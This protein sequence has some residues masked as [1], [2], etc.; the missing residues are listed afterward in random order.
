[1]SLRSNGRTRKDLAVQQCREISLFQTT[2]S[3][4]FF[5]FWFRMFIFIDLKICLKEKTKHNQRISK[6]VS[7]YMKINI[8]FDSL[9]WRLRGGNL[10]PWN[11]WKDVFFSSIEYLT[12]FIVCWSFGL[13]LESKM[14]KLSRKLPK[15]IY[16][17]KL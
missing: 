14:L 3:R 12:N 16:F 5:H 4:F 8:V 13:S 2:Y 1:M 15:D 9:L 6:I 7:G 10:I 17:K 11:V